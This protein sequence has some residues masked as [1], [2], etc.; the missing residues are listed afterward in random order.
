MVSKKRLFYFLKKKIYIC[1]YIQTRDG[2]A[3]RATSSANLEIS[4]PLSPFHSLSPFLFSTTNR[5]IRLTRINNEIAVLQ[6]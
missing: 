5:C 4:L 3:Q 1:I 6:F 2:D